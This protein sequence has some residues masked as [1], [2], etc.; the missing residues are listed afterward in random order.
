MVMFIHRGLGNIFFFF[1]LLFF[2]LL[3]SIFEPQSAES[4]KLIN[5]RYQ[6]GLVPLEIGSVALGASSESAP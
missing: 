5:C 1:F 4:S 3:L 2:V 6:G